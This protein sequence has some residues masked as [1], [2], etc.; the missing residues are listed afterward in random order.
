MIL[1]Q[2]ELLAQRE[3][4]LSEA[5]S[6]AKVRALEIGCAASTASPPKTCPTIWDG[7]E[8]WKHGGTKPTR[9]TGSSA[10]SAWDHINSKRKKRQLL[11]A[12]KRPGSA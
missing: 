6:E 4:A 11:I 1:A 12:R 9:K 5:Q 8:P 10:P 3:A 2:R 7:D